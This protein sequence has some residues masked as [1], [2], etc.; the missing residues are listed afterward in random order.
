MTMAWVLQ[1][2]GGGE[3]IGVYIKDVKG[4]NKTF[5]K[6][7]VL[8]TVVVGLMY[9]LGAAAV[10]MIVPAETLA[11][12]FSNGIF[13]V[14]QLLGSHFNIPSG[15]LVRLV[16]VILLLGNLGSL[17]LWTAA[18]VK[19]FFSEI[20]EG[21]FGK[22]LVKTNDE[23]N[24]TNALVA[25]GIVVS[26]LLIIPALGIGNMDSFLEMLIDMTTATSLLPVLFL[27][28]AYIGLRWKKDDMK[29]DFKFGN[30]TF[31]IIAGV[32]L[33]AVFV[34]VFFMSTVPEPTLMMQAIN[35]TLPEG[36]A[37]PFG[38]LIYNVLGIV[39]FVGF[40]WVCWARYEKKQKA[41]KTK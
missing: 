31:G 3:S 30:R 10:G 36:A 34:F 13:D 24:P 26:I 16:G 39:I 40:A 37:N 22:W 32:F 17:A 12:N 6:I 18:P 15:V 41:E 23:G 27:I 7:M 14:F 20:P 5:V 35:G 38:S 8:S 25:Q 19:I 1:A 9:V 4:G 11:G 2:V 21:V 29:R 28:A 33:M